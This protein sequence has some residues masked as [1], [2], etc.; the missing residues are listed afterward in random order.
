MKRGRRAMFGI[1][2]VSALGLGA[3]VASGLWIKRG[4]TEPRFTLVAKEGDV[5]I[6]TY[7]ATVVAST[8]VDGEQEV[9]LKEGFRR[10]AGY[11]FGKNRQKAKIAMTAPVAAQPSE[12][13]AMTA[14]VSAEPRTGGFTVTFT[15]PEGRTLD[16]LPEPEDARVRLAVVPARTVAAVRFSGRAKTDSVRF[17]TDLLV[18]WAKAA[19]RTTR[20]TAIL[21]Q[22]DPPFVMPL[23]RRNEILLELE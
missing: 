18:A 10:L 4:V 1:L 6:R 9:A 20:G 3:W 19:K 14:P 17:H 12:R 2:I 5:E 13:I 7:G 11:I 15:M 16:N 22:Y 8:D 21:A 23:M